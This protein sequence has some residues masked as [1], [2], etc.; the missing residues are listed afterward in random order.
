M[1]RADAFD[2]GI[3]IDRYLERSRLK[4]AVLF[5]AA[6]ELGALEADGPVE[7]L[8]RFGEQIGMAFQILDDVLDVTGPPERTGKPRGTDVLDGT[9]TLPMIL[10]RA[11][12]PDLAARRPAGRPHAGRRRG[13]LRPDSARPA[14]PRRPGSARSSWCR[15]R[16]AGCRRCPSASAR[17]SIWSPT[18]S[19]SGTPEARRRARYA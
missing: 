13:G 16:S 9:V 11:S 12:D 14:R 8:G 5:R 2:A 6:C 15:R 3:S 10:A 19:S 7:P 4:T 17:R 1:Q 18:A